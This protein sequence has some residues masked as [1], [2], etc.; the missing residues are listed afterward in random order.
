MKQIV[1]R[2]LSLAK[3][4]PQGPVYIVGSREA[5]EEEIEPYSVNQSFWTANQLGCLDQH[6]LG[7]LGEALVKATAPL[8]ITG[9]TGRAPDGVSA[10]LDLANTVR[11]LK[12]LDVA[13]AA[14]CFPANHPAWQGLRYGEDE[15]IRKADVIVVLE[16]DVRSLHKAREANLAADCFARCPGSRVVVHRMQIARSFTLIPIP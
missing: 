14:M 4:H 10:V 3:S 2:A 8:V 11:G 12:V 13:G 16:C 5:M 1:N 9:Y 15:S 6:Q 7:I